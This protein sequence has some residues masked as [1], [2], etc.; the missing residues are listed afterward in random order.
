[1]TEERVKAQA[2][3][4]E[5]GRENFNSIK[6]DKGNAKEKTT[7]CTEPNARYK[8]INNTKRR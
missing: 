4:G 2:S 5:R 8:A 7:T 3:R 6:K 1:V